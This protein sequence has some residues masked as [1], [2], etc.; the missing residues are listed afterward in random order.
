[1]SCSYTMAMKSD[2]TLATIQGVRSMIVLASV[3]ANGDNNLCVCA[4]FFFCVFCSF[5]F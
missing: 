1:M 5:L 4:L 3:D 2:N